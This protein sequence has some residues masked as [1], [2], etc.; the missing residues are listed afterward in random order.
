MRQAQVEERRLLLVG[1][2]VGRSL[3]ESAFLP[4]FLRNMNPSPAAEEDAAAEPCLLSVQP[5]LLLS[6]ASS[7]KLVHMV[8]VFADAAPQPLWGLATML[9]L[10][11][12]SERRVPRANKRTNESNCLPGSLALLFSGPCPML[13]ARRHHQL[14]RRGCSSLKSSW[15]MHL[16]CFVGL[17]PTTATTTTE[18]MNRA[19]S[20]CSDRPLFEKYHLTQQRTFSSHTRTASFQ[21]VL[22]EINSKSSFPMS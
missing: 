9:R 22:F 5:C 12:D 6:L 8:A 21:L 17:S 7:L 19:T 2:S 15:S 3:C 4:C 13:L 16:M 11:S 1:R 10:D 20:R 14:R 18:M